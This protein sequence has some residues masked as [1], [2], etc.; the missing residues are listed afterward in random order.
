[1]FAMQSGSV[2]VCMTYATLKLTDSSSSCREHSFDFI[3]V[4]SLH[5]TYC[6]LFDAAAAAYS[7]MSFSHTTCEKFN[8][9]CC[10][11]PLN[12]KCVFAL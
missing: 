9:N 7:R 3:S 5:H 10:R 6:H 8:T 4:F 2:M 11:R 1:M 12:V